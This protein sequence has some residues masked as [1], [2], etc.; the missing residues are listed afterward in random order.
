[1]FVW[2]GTHL[3]EWNVNTIS[4]ISYIAITLLQIAHRNKHLPKNLYK[5]IIIIKINT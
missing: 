5:T 3:F 2:F 4:T 1:M